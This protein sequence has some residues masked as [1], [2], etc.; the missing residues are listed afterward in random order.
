MVNPYFII[1]AMIAVAGAYGY[2]HHVGW[3]DRD[4][5]MQIEIAKKN[6]EAREK[7]QELAKQLNDQSTKLSEANN[8][9]NQKQSSL[10]RAIRD[11]RL[12]LQ[13]TSCVQATANA[14]TPTGDSPKERSEPNRTVYETSDSDRATLAAIAEIIAQGD[15]NTA[16]LNACVDSYNKAMEIINGKR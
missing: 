7:E 2:G 13:T 8:V 10:D 14:P 15:R 16:Q 3:G 11:G 5:E 6:D 9:I 4:A 1:G 12:R